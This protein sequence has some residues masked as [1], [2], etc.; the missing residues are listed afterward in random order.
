MIDDVGTFLRRIFQSP[1][2]KHKDT[3]GIKQK[4]LIFTTN[5][6]K[7]VGFF[8]E[9]NIFFVCFFKSWVFLKL[10]KVRIQA[11]SFYEL[12]KDEFDLGH[13]IFFIW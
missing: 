7:A 2:A 6:D 13:D 5:V 8:D 12:P 9:S 11:S 3:S 4:K 10:P 1:K